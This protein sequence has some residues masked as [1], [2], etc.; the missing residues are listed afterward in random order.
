MIITSPYPGVVARVLVSE[1]DHVEVGDTIC[2]VELMK[3][4]QLVTSPITAVVEVVYVKTGEVVNVDSA[5]AE[6]RES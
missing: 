4:E 5:I 2:T 3:M 1:A 6:L